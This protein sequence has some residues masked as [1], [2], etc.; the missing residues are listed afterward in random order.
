MIRV[1]TGSSLQLSDLRQEIIFMCYKY[2]SIVLKV[3]V[4]C[5]YFKYRLFFFTYFESI[6]Y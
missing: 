2:I 6:I 5:D 4:H 3:V 1:R